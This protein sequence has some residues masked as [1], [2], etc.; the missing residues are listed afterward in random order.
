MASQTE[1][2]FYTLGTAGGPVPKA[3]R[4]APAHAVVRGDLAILVDC[5]EGAFRQAMQ[6]GIDF[7]RV[8]HI[9]L[10]HH[11][12]DH[13][14]SLFNGLGIYMMAQRAKPL[15]IYGPKG[16]AHIVNALIEA[17]QVPWEIGFG[18]ASKNMP[19][20]RDFVHVTEIEPGARL[21][22]GDIQVSCCEN[23]HY[24]A[25]QS[26]GQP[27]YHSLSL[28]FDA[29]DRSI[30]YTGDTGPCEAL[31]RFAFGA[32]LL[33]GEVIDVERIMARIQSRSLALSPQ[34]LDVYRQHMEAH[35]LS[36]RHLGELATRAQTKHLVAVH[37]TAETR[38]TEQASDYAKRIGEHYSGKISISED[39]SAY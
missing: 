11:H 14:G 28:R 26:F 9:I 23:T 19:H 31:E 33:V 15:T 30:V 37:I 3:I 6:A 32:D 20:P 17:C 39:L 35:H 27:G 21:E 25:E 36:P 16:T 13:I 24:R 4:A 2:K 22:N 34:Q 12:F 7:R 5:G 8:D 38:E 10:S 29:P 18:A 1:T